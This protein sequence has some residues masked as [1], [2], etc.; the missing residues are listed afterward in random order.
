MC[1]ISGVCFLDFAQ[2]IYRIV[3][4]TTPFINDTHNCNSYFTSMGH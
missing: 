4:L 1:Q 2:T 3:T